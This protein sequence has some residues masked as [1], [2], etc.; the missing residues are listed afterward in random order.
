M[1]MAL[2]NPGS[3]ATPT[4]PAQQQKK[5]KDDAQFQA[6][7]GGA[8]RLMDAMRNPDSFKVSSA[9]FMNDGVVCY[10]YRAQNGFGGM[11]VGNAVLTEK[12]TVKTNEME[13]GTKLWNKECANKSGYD[14][15]WEIN[16]AIG[17]E[18][19]LH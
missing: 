15:T 12:G 14:K 17:K 2:V 6:G 18:H 1:I 16:Y 4:S 5:A 13:G 3:T 19:L 11:N 10:E 9:L 7:V 8:K